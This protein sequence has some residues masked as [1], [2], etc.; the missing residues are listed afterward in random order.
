MSNGGLNRSHQDICVERT[1]DGHFAD[2]DRRWLYLHIAVED[3]KNFG[4]AFDLIADQLGNCVA[5]W[6]I[7]LTEYNFRLGSGPS[8]FRFHECFA[9]THNDTSSRFR[10]SGGFLFFSHSG[11]STIGAG[12]PSHP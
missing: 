10:F 3:C 2:H 9:S 12:P 11:V 1:I 7:E 6:A 8:G 4:M 5:D